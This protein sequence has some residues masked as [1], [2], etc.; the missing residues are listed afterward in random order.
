MLQPF[1]STGNTSLTASPEEQARQ[2]PSMSI[3]DH[4]EYDEVGDS[5]HSRDTYKTDNWR[6]RTTLCWLGAAWWLGLVWSGE[7]VTRLL[8]SSIISGTFKT[9][10]IC[11]YEYQLI[12]DW[13]L[14]TRLLIIVVVTLDMFR[15]SAGTDWAVTMS[16]SLQRQSQ[17][18][19]YN[20]QVKG[21]YYYF[22]DHSRSSPSSS[23]AGCLRMW[24]REK[25]RK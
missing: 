18:K 8:G 3:F 2:F 14:L 25:G 20:G 11:E 9:R 1:H 17:D 6:S 22:N 23:A 15:A 4:E 5:H 12:C 19:A 21:D 13:S 10:Q 7:W 16:S 24:M